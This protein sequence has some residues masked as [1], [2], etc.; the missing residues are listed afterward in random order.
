VGLRTGGLVTCLDNVSRVTTDSNGKRKAS[1]AAKTVRHKFEL[2]YP[3]RDYW[4]RCSWPW[5][6]G[7]GELVFRSCEWDV[8]F[9]LGAIEE[10]CAQGRTKSAEKSSIM[11]LLCKFTYTSTGHCLTRPCLP[12]RI[13]SGPDS[14]CPHSSPCPRTQT[15]SSTCPWRNCFVSPNTCDQSP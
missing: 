13:S 9:K 1:M 7:R 3:V 5:V 6:Q 15:R 4:V 12:T 14:R 11:G 10:S 8:G 2:I